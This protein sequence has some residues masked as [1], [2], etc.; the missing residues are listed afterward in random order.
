M[1]RNI[2]NEHILTV[3][4]STYN[5]EKYLKEQ[6]ESV[7]GQD[8]EKKLGI[9]IRL[10][11]RDDGSADG[12]QGILEEYRKDGKL[13]WAAGRNMG[14][15][16]SF[17]ELLV[18]APESEYYAFCDQD[19][20]WFTDKLSRSV[21]RLQREREGI[22][23]ACG[24]FFLPVDADLSPIRR[25]EGR[26]TP[27]DFGRLL[28]YGGVLGCTLVWNRR[29]QKLLRCYGRRR[30][31]RSIGDWHD[32]TVQKIVSLAGKMLY[33]ENP[34]LYYRQHGGNTLGWQTSGFW[35]SITRARR[36]LTTSFRC[37][38]REAQVLWEAYGKC[39][40]EGSG[41]RR[42]LEEVAFYRKDAARRLRFFMDRSFRIRPAEDFFLKLLI[43]LGII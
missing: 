43:I 37:R 30:G 21:E 19:D 14:A 10:F 9:K 16:N 22:P 24:S 25:K 32:W 39:L 7:L 18:S 35:D 36:F 13:E 15:A 1:N 38:S 3:L 29:A 5:G 28:I 20:I 33:D 4:M 6:I 12:T 42:Q 17:W 8:I 34:S 27:T 2:L 23:L 11:V 26:E 31:G 40:P 41:K